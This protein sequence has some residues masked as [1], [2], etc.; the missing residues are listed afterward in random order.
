M[1]AETLQRLFLPPALSRA[2]RAPIF[3]EIINATGNPDLPLLAADNLASHGFVP[4]IG[5]DSPQQAA[6]Q[7]SYYGANFKG[8]YDWLI[9]WIFAKYRS[10]I[11][12]ISEE[13]DY[14]YDYRVVLG[15][16]YDPCRPEL[17][18]PQ[19]FLN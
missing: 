10:S 7:L 18:A 8:S 17:F 14:P 5:P 12:L 9:S 3:V 16:N 11:E 15:A 2:N 4:A 6:T 1:M 13:T 19:A